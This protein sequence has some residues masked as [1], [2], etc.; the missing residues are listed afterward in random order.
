MR[1]L[2]RAKKTKLKPEILVRVPVKAAFDYSLPPHMHSNQMMG[3]NACHTGSVHS[4]FV[5]N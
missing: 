1:N 2:P 5:A 3:L 4:P